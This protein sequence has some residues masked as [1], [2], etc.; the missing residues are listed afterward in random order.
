M[1]IRVLRSTRV[2]QE[3]A[4]SGSSIPSRRTEL[5]RVFR[6]TIPDCTLQC[7]PTKR[8]LSTC[9][10]TIVVRQRH[11]VLF[12]SRAYAKSDSRLPTGLWSLIVVNGF[13][14]SAR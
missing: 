2:V 9:L 8:D 13:E 14:T 10:A 1:N 5:L 7:G 3:I 4:A 6:E 12:G 11:R